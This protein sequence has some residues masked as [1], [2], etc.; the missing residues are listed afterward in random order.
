MSFDGAPQVPLSD[1]TDELI[2]EFI[3]YLP[4]AGIKQY[5]VWD[6]ELLF[7]LCSMKEIVTDNLGMRHVAGIECG[8]VFNS[9]LYYPYASCTYKAGDTQEREH[10][11]KVC[12]ARI[13]EWCKVRDEQIFAFQKELT[14]WQSTPTDKRDQNIGDLILWAVRRAKKLPEY[15]WPTDISDRIVTR[16]FWKNR[17]FPIL[18]NAILCPNKSHS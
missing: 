16:Q 10:A 12:A 1:L 14:A 9:S 11:I 2:T 5:R 3:R 4:I 13:G 7:R 6:A 17:A 18:Y 8:N 15:E